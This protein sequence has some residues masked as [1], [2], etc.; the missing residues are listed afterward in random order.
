LSEFTPPKPTLA[1]PNPT[2]LDLDAR[3]ISGEL[4]SAV[5][6]LIPDAAVVVDSG[7]CI[8][9]A[10][11]QAEE[12][13]GYS[14]GT[15]S[16]QMIESLVPE[17][18]RQRHRQ[19]RSDYLETP[20]KRSMGAGLALTGRRRDGSEFPVDISLAPIERSG[21]HLFVAAVRDVSDQR[22][23]TAAQAQLAAIVRSSLD[24]I[25]STSLEGSITNWNP[26][27]ETLLGY[28][29]NEIIGEH[30]AMLIPDHQSIVLEELL[31]SAYASSHRGA[32]DTRWLHRDGH[33][34][35][36]AVSISPLKDQGGTVLG[37]SSVVRDISERK[38]AEAELRRLFAEEERLER[39]HA[40]TAEI[41]LALLSDTPF[42]ESLTLICARASELVGAPVA[43]ICLKEDGETRITAAVGLVPEMSGAL[44]PAGD[45]IAERVIDSGELLQI[46]PRSELSRIEIPNSNVDGPTLG[47]PIISGGISKASLT[48]VRVPGAEPFSSSEQ[49]FGEALAAQAALAFELVRARRDREEMML[50]EDRERIARDLHDHVIQRLFATGM[51]LQGTLG[52][53]NEPRTRERVSSAVDTLDET[54]REIRNTIFSLS[55]R[56]TDNDRLRA[57]VTEIALQAEESL[58]FAPTLRFEG[59]VDAGISEALLPHVL[60]V[61][62]EA[63]SNVAR[64]ARA[65]VVEVRIALLASDLVVTVT[66]DGIGI[67]AP[68][69]SSGLANL[70]DR[71]NLLGG[72]FEISTSERGGTRLEWRIPLLG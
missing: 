42:K 14:R 69:R 10:N 35:D 18:V 55:N 2:P 52:T 34:I 70:H 57:Q 22:A 59:P 26:A 37:F 21:E 29:G 71:A 50:V 33:E 65:S 72:T 53:T 47:I 24:A 27:A 56:E 44:L 49:I 68:T 54:V 15:L 6:A 13:F 63:L 58:G 20:Q 46:A 31:D 17:R 61:V 41:R 25:I 12:L 5:I 1:E 11:E 16:G 43:V 36:V 8:V 4:L 66:D 60:A 40:A 7:G 64:H 9:S 32:R 3:V 48:L 28:S 39:Q 67:A 19:H 38:T 30:I 62:R 23:A 51:S 45:S